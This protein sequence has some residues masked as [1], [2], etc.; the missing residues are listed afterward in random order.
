MFTL[1]SMVVHRIFERR[2]K[3]EKL[4]PY[5]SLCGLG[6]YYGVLGIFKVGK[7]NTLIKSPTERAQRTRFNFRSDSVSSPSRAM[8]CMED[9]VSAGSSSSSCFQHSRSSD[10]IPI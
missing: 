8:K 9:A 6:E 4:R 10:T 3:A 2:Q 5:L 1:S 7:G